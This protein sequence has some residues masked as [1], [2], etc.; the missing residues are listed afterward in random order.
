[1]QALLRLDGIEKVRAGLQK[2]AN[3]AERELRPLVAA[4]SD[5]RVNLLRAMGISELAKQKVLDAANEARTVLGL[6][7]LVELTDS[8]SLR[9]GLEAPPTA[10]PQRIVKAQAA[11]DVGKAGGSA[12]AG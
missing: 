11:A 2:I 8:T 9:S 12:T 1:M 6:A 4:E 3:A 7:P 5:A 10:K